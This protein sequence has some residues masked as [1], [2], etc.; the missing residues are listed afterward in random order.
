MYFR[1]DISGITH[2]SYDGT[3][4]IIIFASAITA[5]SKHGFRITDCLLCAEYVNQDPR[6]PWVMLIEVDVKTE[7][8]FVHQSTHHSIVGD[9]IPNPF[10]PHLMSYLPTLN[11]RQSDCIYALLCGPRYSF[12]GD[13][14]L[15]I[16][17]PFSK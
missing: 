12:F 1:V 14:A 13:T 8:V 17:N 6:N 7:L 10:L 4:A 2:S 15:R 11:D 9:P 3:Y 16:Q 5:P